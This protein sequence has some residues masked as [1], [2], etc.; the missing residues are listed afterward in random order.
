MKVVLVDHAGADLIASD[1]GNAN[2]RYAISVKSHTLNIKVNEEKINIESKLYNFDEHNIKQLKNFAENFNLKPVVSIVIAQPEIP[3]EH[4]FW[5]KKLE[6]NADKYCERHDNLVIDVF[7][8]LLDDAFEMIKEGKDYCTPKYSSPGGFNFKFENKYFEELL[9]D[10]HI[11]HTR[12]SFDKLSYMR[13]LD[14]ENPMDINAEDECPW[15][16]NEE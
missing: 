7:T 6:R 4:S 3:Q 13:L 15:G 8:F 12:L 2:N 5:Q 10:K 11:D 9:A 1:L 16:D 14:P